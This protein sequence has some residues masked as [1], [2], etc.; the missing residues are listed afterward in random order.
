MQ[1]I[2]SELGL[3]SDLVAPPCVN[4]SEVV[5]NAKSNPPKKLPAY[6]GAKTRSSASLPLDSDIGPQ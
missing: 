3:D 5:I 4:L 1:L 2:D 6:E